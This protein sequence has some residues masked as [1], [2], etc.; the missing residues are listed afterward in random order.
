MP[1][2]SR[3]DSVVPLFPDGPRPPAPA[4]LTAKEAKVWKD[5]VDSMPARWLSTELHPIL[6]GYCSHVVAAAAIWPKYLLTLEDPYAELK[7]LAKLRALY[8]QEAAAIRQ[9]SSKL[10]LTRMARQ[11]RHGVQRYQADPWTL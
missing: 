8:H 7:S 3:A 10:G 6:R 2:R 1:R 11:E 9:A 4:D 5:T